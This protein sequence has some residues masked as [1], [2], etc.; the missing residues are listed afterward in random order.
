MTMLNLS[1]V[2][3]GCTSLAMLEAAVARRTVNGEVTMS[4][5]YLPKRQAEIL[6]GG[7]LY[8]II[9]HQLVARATILRFDVAEQGKH[10]I[11]LEALVIPVRAYPRRAHQGWRYLDA[12]DAPPDLG[13][14]IVGGDALPSALLGEL[15][16]LSLI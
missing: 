13:D 9:K 6:G 5:R 3:Y 14:G 11:V 12:Q 15:S 16:G 7:S 4:T 10:D 1:K 2:A 8:W